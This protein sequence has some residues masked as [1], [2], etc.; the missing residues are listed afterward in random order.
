[1]TRHSKVTLQNVQELDLPFDVLLEILIQ[2]A[3]I[4]GNIRSRFIV[5]NDVKDDNVCITLK[6]EVKVTLLGFGLAYH[7]GKAD[8]FTAGTLLQR[9]PF[10]RNNSHIMHQKLFVVVLRLM[11]TL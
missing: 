5:R 6:K 2:T 1:M 7:N 4:L 10:G 8:S 9:K 11:C 3:K